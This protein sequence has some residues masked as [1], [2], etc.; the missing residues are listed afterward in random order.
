MVEEAYYK[1]FKTDLNNFIFIYTPPKVGSTTLVTS[2]RISLGNSYNI[3]HIHDDLM[4]NVLTG[5]N[6]VSINDIINY[7]SRRGKNVYVIDVY[8]EPI[9]RKMS[10]FFEKI[11]CYHFNNNEENINNY[12]I[13]RV[14]DRFNKLFPHLAKEE[15]YF[16]KYNI[17][18]PIAFNFEKK[19]TLQ[20]INGVQYVKLRL[21]DSKEWGRILSEILHS[22]I[23]I[24][25]DYRTDQKGFAELYSKFKNEYSLPFNYFELIKNCKYFNFYFSEEERNS[26]LEKWVNKLCNEVVSYT[27]NEYNFYISI[28]LENQFYGDIQPEHYLDSGCK[29]RCCSLKRKEIFFKAK[30]GEIIKEKIRHIEAVKENITKKNHN[31]VKIVKKLNEIAKLNKKVKSNTLSPILNNVVNK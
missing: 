23:V 4:L 10:E 21:M 26:Y 16:D 12:K 24:I 30:R 1:L 3:I 15:H 8:R 17:K 31:V 18:H 19:Y 29:C 5:I 2:L 20:V 28:C 14:T 25:N 22:D 9:E 13:S 7:I 6:N 27:K 11:S